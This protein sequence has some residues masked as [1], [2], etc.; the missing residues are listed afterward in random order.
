MRRWQTSTPPSHFTVGDQV[1]EGSIGGLRSYLE[2]IRSTESD[3]YAKLSPDVDRMQ[4]R[5]KT[6]ALLL[7][8]GVVAGVGTTVY[9]LATRPD[10]VSPPVGD[11]NFAAKLGELSACNDR[12][13][14]R[15]MTFTGIGLGLLLAGGIGA[16]A[17]APK[18][19]DT[20]NFVNRHNSLSPRPM[21]LDLG[22]DPTRRFAHAGATF[23][24]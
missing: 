2:T 1:F 9:G 19:S 23:S 4:S 15:F 17:I 16:M 10:C 21:R 24:F 22:Y 3:L 12:G 14:Q 8:A 18:R 6:A 7:G 11:P 20:F 5:M 13:T